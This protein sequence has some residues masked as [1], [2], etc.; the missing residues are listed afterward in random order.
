MDA[1]IIFVCIFAPTFV[2]N[3]LSAGRDQLMFQTRPRGSRWFTGLAMAAATAILLAIGMPLA[4]VLALVLP[5][6]LASVL[7][8]WVGSGDWIV[9]KYRVLG[10]MRRRGSGLD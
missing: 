5:G 10:L 9:T 6:P 3:L 7:G 8:E 4:W 2:L 1:L